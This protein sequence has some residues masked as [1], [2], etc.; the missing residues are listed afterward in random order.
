MKPLG[1][2]L[3]AA[4]LAVPLIWV[5]DLMAKH[6][7]VAVFSQLLGIW[8]LIAMAT[9][10]AMATRFGAIERLF[11]GLD[12]V[13]VLHKWLGIAALALILLHDTIDAE[14]D[15]LP[16]NRVLEEI[17]DTLGEISLYGI[18]ILVVITVAT[19]IPYHLWRWTHRIIGVFF[20]TGALHYLLIIKPFANGDPLGLYVGTIC[21]IGT[22][23]ALY[24]ALPARLRPTH[25]YRITEAETLGPVTAITLAPE[26]RGLSH[27]AGQFANITVDGGEAHPFTI[28]AAPNDARHLR[29]S[30]SALGDD[31]TR[32]QSRLAP[33]QNVRLEGPHGRFFPSKSGPRIWIAGGIGITP[34]LAWVGA[35]NEGDP[36]TTLYYCVKSE[37]EAA[38]LSELQAAAARLPNLSLIL[39][40]SR[41]Q[42]RLSAAQITANHRDLTTAHVAFCGPTPMRDALQIALGKEGL[43]PRR[44]HYEAFEFRTGVGLATLSEWL[45]TRLRD[46][47]N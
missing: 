40:E 46:R 16:G 28:S 38:H 18:L 42:G 23:A 47:M 2:T 32:L 34:F 41:T 8:A 13:Y 43:T 36:A 29:M 9:G 27:R 39:W 20:V 12:R 35:M 25:G 19:F 17:G 31:T 44:F 1:L 26:G 15:G 6:S 7:P 21:L 5:P 33:G 4:L 37:A 3:I 10:Q 45:L 11:G 30:I 14:I 24:R 22:L